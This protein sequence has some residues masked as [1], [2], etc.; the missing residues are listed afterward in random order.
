MSGRGTVEWPSRPCTGEPVRPDPR[1]TTWF[2]PG[3]KSGSSTVVAGLSRTQHLIQHQRPTGR[4]RHRAPTLPA[5]R[6]NAGNRWLDHA[7]LLTPPGPSGRHLDTAPPAPNSPERNPLMLSSLAP[8]PT[9][10]DHI[11][12]TASHPIMTD[13]DDSALV[14]AVRDG[15][16]QAAGVL[17][18]RHYPF[19]VRAARGISN[20][21]MA[22]D[23]A[24]EAMTRVVAALLNGLGPDRAFRAYLLTTMRNLFRDRLRKLNGEIS[25]DPLEE[26]ALDLPEP[27]PS[28]R[29][30]DRSVVL[31]VMAELPERWREV[32]WRTIVVEEPLHAVGASMGLSAN[33]VAAL[34]YRA[35]SAFSKAYVRA[36]STPA[37]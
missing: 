17:Y 12:A 13:W 6:S 27:D 21:G 28:E 8:A 16:M 2:C 37:A 35:R 14:Q 1:E 9:A 20:P 15:D 4:A 34:S 31:E 29:V 22:E 7:G 5:D 25:V 30:L 11:H 18:A 36:V 3:A 26:G 32:L 23:L 33:A 24:S 19:A 10:D